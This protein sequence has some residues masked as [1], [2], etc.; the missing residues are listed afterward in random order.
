MHHTKK[1]LTIR[2]CLLHE[3]KKTRDSKKTQ[4][5]SLFAI[6]LIR[7]TGNTN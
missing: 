4:N 5:L 3:L 1:E 6:I 2:V 7:L